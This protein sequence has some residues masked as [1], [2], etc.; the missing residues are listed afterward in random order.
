MEPNYEDTSIWKKEYTQDGR[1]M[2][3][4]KQT[5]QT[6]RPRN[7]SVL[8]KAL[9]VSG[10]EEAP[11][12][13][14]N[15]AKPGNA[16][17]WYIQQYTQDKI[18][19]FVHM[20]TGVSMW[21]LPEGTPQSAVKFITHLTDNGIPYYENVETGTTSWTLPLDQLSTAARRTSMALKKMNRRQSEHFMNSSNQ[22]ALAV[23]VVKKDRKEESSKHGER[24][25]RYIT[26]SS[27]YR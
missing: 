3:I 25:H 6:A 26:S 16:T 14:P 11:S 8:N 17:D 24:S 27:I 22:D 23:A 19:F 10:H 2:Y 18:P 7:N 1:P 9:S 20:R 5:G 13:A 4:N 21:S 12:V 15:A